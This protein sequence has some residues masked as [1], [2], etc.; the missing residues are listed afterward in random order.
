MLKCLIM[1]SQELAEHIFN[2]RTQII[3]AYHINTKQN[4]SFIDRDY[5]E[6]YGTDYSTSLAS[7]QTMQHSGHALFLCYILPRFQ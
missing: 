2:L 1:C 4:Y 7:A 3:S 6:Y 5:V